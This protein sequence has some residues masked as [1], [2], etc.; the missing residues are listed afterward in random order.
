MTDSSAPTTQPAFHYSLEL[1]THVEILL[2]EIDIPLDLR[3]P[4][5]NPRRMLR[6]PCREIF[7]GPIP[8]VSLDLLLSLCPADISPGLVPVPPLAVKASA[9]AK[10]YR[11][12]E[13]RTPLEPVRTGVEITPPASPSL[14]AEVSANPKKNLPTKVAEKTPERLAQPSPQPTAIKMT[15][16]PDSGITSAE[17]DQTAPHQ[18]APDQPDIPPQTAPRKSLFAGLPIFRKKPP[19]PDHAEKPATSE[20][21]SEKLKNKPAESK[22]AQDS[23]VGPLPPPPSAPAAQAELAVSSP[24]E[25]APPGQLTDLATPPTPAPIA[26]PEVDQTE[27]PAG[28][29]DEPPALATIPEPI[30]SSPSDKEME[31]VPVDSEPQPLACE[32]RLQEIFLT[33]DSLPLEKVMELCG[34]LPGVHACILTR[35][36]RVVSTHAAPENLDLV[37][38]TAN[39][40][41]LLENLQDSAR[42]MGLGHVHTIT[43]HSEKSPVSIFSSGSTTLLV[44]HGDRGFVPGVRERLSQVVSALDGVDFPHSLPSTT[45]D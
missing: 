39:G 23:A 31:L 13:N 10:N 22:P 1:P 25:P 21:T 44:T 9:A 12:R 7:Q 15:E 45:H 30:P 26:Q 20:P 18:Q 4:T 40:S 38:L 16:P 29:A 33:E 35:Q 6:L 27:K 37:A 34:R 28:S 5:F 17:T 11:L 43:I 41:R 24:P 36:S 19:K 14:L 32:E 8:R 3:S 2:E 42:Q